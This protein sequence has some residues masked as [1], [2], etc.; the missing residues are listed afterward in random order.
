[1]Y[2]ETSFLPSLLLKEFIE[3]SIHVY[4]FQIRTTFDLELHVGS[5]IMRSSKTLNA[6]TYIETICGVM[7]EG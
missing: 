5:K 2:L 4:L 7:S 6:V 3:T 1:M